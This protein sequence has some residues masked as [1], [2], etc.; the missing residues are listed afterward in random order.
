MLMA[1]KDLSLDDVPQMRRAFANCIEYLVEGT[2]FNVMYKDL[3]TTDIGKRR[4]P[5]V[6]ILKGGQSS[7]QNSQQLYDGISKENDDEFICWIDELKYSL[8]RTA[9]TNNGK[10]QQILETLQDSLQESLS[11]PFMSCK[12]SRKYEDISVQCT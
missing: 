6:F 7:Q 10:H 2:D 1:E 4:M 9:N 11:L 3:N 12:V 8:G 5:H